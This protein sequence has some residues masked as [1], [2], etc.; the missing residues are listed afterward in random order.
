MPTN[1]TIDR[2]IANLTTPWG[3][4]RRK[5]V[6]GTGYLVDGNL[7]RGAYQ[8]YLILRIGESQARKALDKSP[9]RP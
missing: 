6:V 4:T 7:I 8:D 3:A 2:P 5:M 9:P 1:E